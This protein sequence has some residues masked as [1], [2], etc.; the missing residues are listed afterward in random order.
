MPTTPSNTHRL[1][2]SFVRFAEECR[3]LQ[4]PFYAQL[5][6]SI[7]QDDQLLSIAAQ[8]GSRPETNLFFAA[9]QYLLQNGV[10]HPVANFYP[11]VTSSPQSGDPFPNFRDFCFTHQQ[12]ILDLIAVRRVQTNEVRRC[13]FLM[14]AFNLVYQQNHQ[15]P[16]AMIDVGTSAGLNLLWDQ[17]HYNYNGQTYGNLDAPVQIQTEL[18]GDKHPSLNDPLPEVTYRI[19]LDLH[20][21]D[22]KEP[23]QAA[24]LRAL[25]WP[26]HKDRH[27]MLRAA[28]QMFINNP[29]T[30]RT[31]D[32]LQTVPQTL[33]EIPSNTTLCI[34]HSFTL[35]QFSPE[36]REQFDT[37]LTTHSKIRPIYRISAEGNSLDLRTYNQGKCTTQN[38]A[39]VNPHGRW[40]NWLI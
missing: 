30:L 37:L 3:A 16:L 10:E 20:P 21:V 2:Q 31:G 40:I 13:A 8:A 38:L 29:Q 19:G 11:N 23:D 17:Y 1:A 14:P 24:W 18:R 35:N 27:H 36:M 39:E 9:V 15:N 26:E 32:A 6:Q 25:I 5:S 4:S 28:I 33:N 12:A 22:V 7:A 34:C